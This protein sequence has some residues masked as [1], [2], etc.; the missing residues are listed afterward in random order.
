MVAF[1]LELIIKQG[2]PSKVIKDDI[3]ATSM[4][5]FILKIIVKH[6]DPAKENQRLHF[7]NIYDGMIK[8][9]NSQI[10]KVYFKFILVLSLIG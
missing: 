5:T 9:N 3:I 8:H 2:D 4:V 6:G 10:S 7:T 1:I